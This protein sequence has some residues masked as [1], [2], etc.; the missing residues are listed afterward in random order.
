M[1]K[2]GRENSMFGLLCYYQFITSLR[3][4]FQDTGSQEGHCHLLPGYWVQEQCWC[5]PSDNGM[6]HLK[7]TMVVSFNVTLLW[8]RILWVGNL[9][10]KS[11][12]VALIAV[13]RPV[14]IYGWHL[15]V[16]A[17]IRKG[18]TDGRLSCLLLAC[19][20]LFQQSWFDLPCCCC[21]ELNPFAAGRTAVPKLSL[22][23]Y[24][25]VVLS[26]LG[27]WCMIRTVEV[28]CLGNW[29][30]TSCHSPPPSERQLWALL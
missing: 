15:K 26:L 19:P 16:A 9:T 20:A 6:L 12:L 8:I 13:E 22:W 23:V 25:S 14:L 3:L 28:L 1:C 4:V 24:W 11:G 29:V 27:F 7:D 18:M 5:L 30:T 21:W 17:R 2:D 10:W